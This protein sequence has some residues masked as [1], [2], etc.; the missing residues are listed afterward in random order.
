MKLQSFCVPS[1]SMNTK[2]S[3]RR[4]MSFAMLSFLIYTTPGSVVV[5]QDFKY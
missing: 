1:V 3:L 2:T 4:V 5:A